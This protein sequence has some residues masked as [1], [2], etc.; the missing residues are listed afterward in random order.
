MH[1]LGKVLQGRYRITAR[2]AAGSMGVVYRGERVGLGRAVA[3][4]FLHDGAAPGTELRARF[5]IEA[6]AASRLT[7]PNCVPVIDFGVDAGA[8][9][10]VMDFIDGRSL[11]DV[12]F[13]GPLAIPRALALAHQVLAGLAHA[14]AHGVIHRDIKPEN[15]LVR[16]DEA[17]E[18]VHITDFGLA[19]LDAL[20]ISQDVAIGTPSYMSPEQ[21][22]G[23]PVDARADVYAAGIL[24][25]ELLAGVKPFRGRSPFETMHLQREAPVPSFEE[26]A[27]D[28]SV[29][30]GVERVVRRAL[31]KDRDERFRSATELAA[32]LDRALSIERED[33]DDLAIEE[34]LAAAT[35]HRWLHRLGWL[36]AAATVAAAAAIAISLP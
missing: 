33:S 13:D 6:R 15:I 31:A 32:A 16:L 30:P 7:H 18:H 1:R 8:P 4:K 28:R 27:P 25:F 19:K 12:L 23:L 9:F 36:A 29:P 3:I 14:H 2:L 20:G 21:T 24:L 11:R 10:L 35:S 5:S 34:L 26:V 22:L 17:G